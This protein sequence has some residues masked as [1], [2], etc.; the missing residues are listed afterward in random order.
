MILHSVIVFKCL[1]V[2]VFFVISFVDKSFDVQQMFGFLRTL[3]LCSA[4]MSFQLY[5]LQPL[6]CQLWLPLCCH[7]YSCL[8]SEVMQNHAEYEILKY[9]NRIAV[10]IVVNNLYR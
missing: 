8:F 3:Q 1:R 5:F 9:L 10:N 6:P 7:F 4:A 2:R